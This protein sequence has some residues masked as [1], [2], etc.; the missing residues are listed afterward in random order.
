MTISYRGP[1]STNRWLFADPSVWPETLY[2][3]DYNPENRAFTAYVVSGP[4]LENLS[5]AFFKGEPAAPILRSMLPSIVLA[6]ITRR[7]IRRRP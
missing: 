6:D 5:P 1:S 3:L 2:C 4:S 7:S